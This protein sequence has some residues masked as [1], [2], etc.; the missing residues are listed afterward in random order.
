MLDA[1]HASLFPPLIK[2]AL[3]RIGE[4]VSFSFPCEIMPPCHFPQT[5]KF[6]SHTSISQDGAL[7]AILSRGGGEIS[8]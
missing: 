7:S 3:T 8:D 1:Q 5:A 2:Q 6:P 4:R